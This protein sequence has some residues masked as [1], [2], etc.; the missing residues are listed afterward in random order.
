MAQPDS[1]RL[2]A[3]SRFEADQRR[4]LLQLAKGLS[5]TL[6][7]DFFRSM[8]KSLGACLHVDYAYIGELGGTPVNRLATLAVY[9]RRHKSANFEQTLPGTAAGQVVQDGTFARSQEVKQL[10]P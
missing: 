3:K 7:N 2:Q 9:R 1:A 10:F 8:V 4:R 5:A 6:G